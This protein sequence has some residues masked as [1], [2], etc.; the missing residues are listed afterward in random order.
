MCELCDLI[1]LGKR[2]AVDI[3]GFPE[4]AEEI[5][6]ATIALSAIKA[7]LNLGQQAL[8]DLNKLRMKHVS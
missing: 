5:T 6:N 1:S 2:C 8:N 4:D 3:S 7:C